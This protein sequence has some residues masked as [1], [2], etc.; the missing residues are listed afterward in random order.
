[1][2]LPGLIA[3]RIRALF[4]KDELDADMAE[5]M[6]IHVELQAA[7]HLKAGMAADEAGFAARRD[8]GH[9]D[10][11]QEQVRDQRGFR[12]L[13]DLA[14]DL[15]YGWRQLGRNPGFTAVAV[16]TLALGI[17]V[18]SATISILDDLILR[19]SLRNH[20]EKLAVLHTAR[21]G[22]GRSFRP[23]SYAEYTTIRD[24]G[25]IFSELAAMQ[26]NTSA[27][28]RDDD[29]RRRLLCLV[30]RN[31]FS[32]LAV[33][34]LRG[35]F[36]TAEEAS[37]NS[38]IAVAVASYAFWQRMGGR[39]DFL[40]S[41]IQID[42]RDFT[43]VGITPPGF[44]GLQWSLG[45]D[46][47]LPLG[48]SSL[49]VG[50][51]GFSTVNDLL[52]SRTYRLDLVGHL[53]P[54]LTLAAAGEA[55]APLN[56]RL[57]QQASA[58]PTESRELTLSVP[59]RFNLNNTEPQDEGAVGIYALLA[60]GMTVTVL[61]VAC[62]NVAN[63]LFS[64]GVSRH[65]EIAIRLCLGA[66]RSRIV[67]QLLVEG[68]L[69]ALAG[70]AA[71]LLLGG[72]SNH[73]MLQMAGRQGGYFAFNLRTRLDLPLL[74]ATSLLCLLATVAFSLAPALRATRLN[75]VDDIKQ[76]GGEQTGSGRWLRFFSPRHCVV[77]AQISL[78]FTLLFST[79]LLLHAVLNSEHDRGFE[80]DG[81]I[82]ANLDY[83]LAGT[84]SKDVPARQK[85]LLD[86]TAG[87]PGVER[88]AL[89]STV[90]F[91]YETNWWRI[92]P[93]GSG[94]TGSAHDSHDDSGRFASYTAVSRGYFS[95]LG[96]PVLRGRDFTE[97]EGRQ[98]GGPGVAIIDDSLGRALFGSQDPIGRHIATNKAE[99]D[100]QH[101]DREIEIVGIVRSP[102]EDAFQREEALPRIYRPLGQAGTENTYL[103]VKLAQ[104]SA[105]AAQVAVLRREM[106]ML[107]PRTPV[108][109][110][111]P[112][113]GL[114]GGNLNVWSLR[115]IVAL[116]TTFGAIAVVLAVVGLYGLKSYVVA[117]R[118]REIGVRIA[119]GARSSDV[120]DLI[121]R[122]G[123]LQAVVGIAAGLCLAVVVGEFLSKVLY[124]VKP[125]EPLTLT[126]VALVL[127]SVSILACLIPAL[128]ATRINP[129][130]A[131]RS[132]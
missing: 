66:S 3:R 101:A 110:C 51:W 53:R 90:P 118:T 81:E 96:I 60:I 122:Q 115:F 94:A 79:G 34:P 82:V 7:A 76:Q 83:Y 132:E 30:S 103:H 24:S 4:R 112:L 37:P 93:I 47:W 64:R 99:A 108:L 23:F 14:Q 65:R 128:R 107:D 6:R 11:I 63:M 32:V 16:L 28:G 70:G 21:V 105:I 84:P 85:A 58:G 100:G 89:A 50:G 19:P 123:V 127:G 35:R 18:N 95:T 1:M 27:V 117:R 61:L 75:L 17:G 97:S 38:G 57:N 41:H 54:G 77:M 52:D 48:M 62:L 40:G 25:G 68:F 92:F 33:E 69:L 104:D 125:V 73:V 88:A 130:D 5:E 31:Y 15:G 26:F 39:D 109:L 80:T 12:W 42:G 29:V 120:L 71:G 74:G 131:L 46:A 59:S 102:R 119:L 44:G 113:A 67:R 2:R 106:R 114:I 111:E 8:F 49:L 86:R 9:L 22:A 20:H 116:F 91:N 13:A 98:G 10:G 45:P 43:V 121:L 36:F 124:S 72:W 55:L 56:A 126:G 78:S 87:L 129:S